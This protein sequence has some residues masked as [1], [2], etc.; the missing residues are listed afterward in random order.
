[1]CDTIDGDKRQLFSTAEELSV[2]R[3]CAAG[4]YHL[5]KQDIVHRDIA[6]RNVLLQKPLVAKVADFGMARGAMLDNYESTT[7]GTGLKK[8]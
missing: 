6:A 7:Y 4:L 5:H 2:I 3:D 1:M 8:I